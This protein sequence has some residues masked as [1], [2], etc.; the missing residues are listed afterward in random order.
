MRK[1]FR[2]R[3]QSTFIL[4]LTLVR[5]ASAQV[6]PISFH[7]ETETGRTQFRIGEV[8][9]ITLTF[10]SSAPDTWI[11]SIN[12]RD[13]SMLSLKTDTFTA[14]PAQGTSDPLRYRFNGPM[15]FNGPVGIR[16]IEKSTTAQLDLNQWIR[17]DQPGFY[18]VHGAFHV[19][20]SAPPTQGQSIALESNEI[21]IQI[22]ATDPAW[23]QRELQEAVATLNVFPVKPDSETFHTRMNA[24]RR[25]W[26]LDTPDSV[27]EA[28]RLLGTADVQVCQILRSGLLASQHRDQAIA[29][30]KQLLRSPDQPVTPVFLQTMA[31]LESWHRIPNMQFSRPDP[32]AGR[33][34]EAKA[35]IMQQLRTELT[36]VIP[37]K[38]DTARALSLKT[39]LDEM[40]PGSAPSSFGSELA[41]LFTKLPLQQ[42]SELL[43]AQWKK[44]AGP[45]MLPALREIY[46]T[47]SATSTQFPPVVAMAVERLYELDPSHGRTLLLDEMERPVPRLPFRTLAILPDATLP[48]LDKLLAQHLEQNQSTEE[49]IARYATAAILTPVKAWYAKRDAMMRSRTSSNV[50]NIASPACEPP[51]VAYFLRV[52]PA[53]GEQVLR[54]SLGERS[55]PMGR[56]WMGIL[57][58]TASY[59]AGAEWE[60]TAVMALQDSTVVIKLDAVNAL[61]QH[62]SAASKAAVWEAFQYW[63]EWWKDRP[64]ELNDENRRFEQVFLEAFAKARN[65]DIT[66]A[67]LANLRDLCITQA[68]TQRVEEFRRQWSD[69]VKPQ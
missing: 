61:G 42:Q 62:G 27:R 32:D 30:M 23:Q 1:T 69:T 63:H 29:A 20:R 45:E 4:A 18:R 36:E 17:F 58:R 57:G 11:I 33:R 68:C 39:I 51:L 66:T 56:C 64:A 21:G 67:D 22:L 28:G 55:Y 47:A 37:N 40:C 53:F 44:I 13:R 7:I 59:Y 25:I 35:A 8:I 14:S 34:Y 43:G 24:A 12:G 50:P 65:W 10:G 9:G 48:S 46:D 3:A 5:S 54:A 60:K 15:F 49:L 31:E 26:Y 41:A 52:E 6:P 16:L 2:P 38:R 19:T